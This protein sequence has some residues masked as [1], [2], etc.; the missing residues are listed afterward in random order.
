[1]NCSAPLLKVDLDYVLGM[2][3]RMDMALYSK[4]EGEHEHDS[5]SR[6]EIYQ[7]SMMEVDYA[8]GNEPRA[9]KWRS[10]D[11]MEN[12]MLEG[13]GEKERKKRGP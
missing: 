6:S 3:G 4:E 10:I 1:M 8:D 2:Y 13:G 9:I 11:S 5:V 12:G 7:G